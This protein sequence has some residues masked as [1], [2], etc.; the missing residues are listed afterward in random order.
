MISGALPKTVLNVLNNNQSA[1]NQ[2]AMLA[3]SSQ[4]NTV[5][6]V[7]ETIILSL[8]SETMDLKSR[9]EEVTEKFFDEDDGITDD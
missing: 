4:E 9:I 7:L 3:E 6:E 1:Y 8:F 5:E 2:Y